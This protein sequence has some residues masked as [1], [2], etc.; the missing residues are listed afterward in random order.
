MSEIT[1]HLRSNIKKST[2]GNFA[3]LLSIPAILL[4]LTALVY[5]VKQNQDIR[6]KAQ[7]FKDAPP[8]TTTFTYNGEGQRLSK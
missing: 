5:L 2:R 8:G 3:K 7:I 1:S 4:S 6:E